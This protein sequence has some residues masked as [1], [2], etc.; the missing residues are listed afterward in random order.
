VGRGK[1]AIQRRRRARHHQHS[2]R[3]SLP[4]H[5]PP[6]HLSMPSLLR[7]S[8][9][10]Q[11]RSSLPNLQHLLHLDP[12]PRSM[13][14]SWVLERPEWL[15][16][17]WQQL[18]LGELG[19]GGDVEGEGGDPRQRFLHHLPSSERTPPVTFALG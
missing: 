17:Q 3:L 4:S 6:L 14:S 13:G 9:N 11:G 8:R 18:C 12:T 10:L 16:R 2:R 15:Q 7:A 1:G 19:Q 5:A